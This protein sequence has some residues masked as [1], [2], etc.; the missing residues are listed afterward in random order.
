[1][2]NFE[3]F[4]CEGI[5]VVYNTVRW[6]MAF[7]SNDEDNLMDNAYPRYENKHYISQDMSTIPSDG[8]TNFLSLSAGAGAPTVT[9]IPK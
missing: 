3:S 7:C 6:G 2:S 1:M 4:T 5:I 8:W 9:F